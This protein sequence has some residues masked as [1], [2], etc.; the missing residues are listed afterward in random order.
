MQYRE[1]VSDVVVATKSPTYMYKLAPMW[2]YRNIALY[3]VAAGAPAV[4]FIVCS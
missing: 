3:G 1:G 4:D 2:I